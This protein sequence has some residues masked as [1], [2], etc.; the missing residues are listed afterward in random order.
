MTM[1]KTFVE[2]TL[3]N[4]SQKQ[5]YLNYIICGLA[6]EI[7]ACFCNVCDTEKKGE[8]ITTC[9]DNFQYGYALTIRSH[10]FPKS[11]VP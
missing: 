4:G 3:T 1:L 9:E 11:R 8:C 7:A 5:K 2:E 10:V 6:H